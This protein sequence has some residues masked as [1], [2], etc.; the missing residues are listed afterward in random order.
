MFNYSIIKKMNKPNKPKVS[1]AKKYVPKTLSEKDKKKQIKS[2]QDKTIRPKLDSFKSKR[3]SWVKKF[4][5]KYKNKISN[6]K[7]IN[8]NL[9]SYEG[10]KQVIKKGMG[11]YFT[12][13]SR[14]NQSKESWA[15]AR[16]A[17][18]LLGGKAQ[19][20]DKDILKKYGK[21]PKFKNLK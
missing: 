8:D 4:E 7:F 6:K 13:G 1:Y 16:L 9:L 2:I 21:I 11:A 20:L 14:P 19:K 17:S 15:L 5:D 3:S 12:S 18:A 10:Q